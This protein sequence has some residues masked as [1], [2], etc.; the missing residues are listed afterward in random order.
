MSLRRKKRVQK[1]RKEFKKKEKSLE[2]EG[3]II[4]RAE[5]RFCHSGFFLLWLFQQ[6][7]AGA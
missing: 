1:E 7:D 5:R 3:K 6:T 4:W 2:R